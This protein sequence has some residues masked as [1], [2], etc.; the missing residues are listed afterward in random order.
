MEGIAKMFIILLI[1]ILILTICIY[2]Y[3]E[4]NPRKVPLII[5][6][7]STWCIIALTITL[8]FTSMICISTHIESNN[9]VV[10]YYATQETEVKSNDQTIKINQDIAIY[11]NWRESLWFGNFVTQKVEGLKPLQ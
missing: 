6:E 1:T 8:F 7:I 10:A 2:T 3:S 11:Q 4:K 9:A 5:E